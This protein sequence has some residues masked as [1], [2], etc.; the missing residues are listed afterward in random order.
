MNCRRTTN[1]APQRRSPLFTEPLESRTLLCGFVHD[2]STVPGPHFIYGES[3]TT[4]SKQSTTAA[5]LSSFTTLASMQTLAATAALPAGWS[6]QDIGSV[7]KVGSASLDEATGNFAVSGGGADVWSTADGFHFAYSTLTGNGQIVARVASVQNTNGLAKAGVMFRESMTPGSKNAFVQV[8]PTNGASFQ[9]RDAT[10]GTTANIGS[11]ASGK[12]PIWLRLTR[13]GDTFI[14]ARSSNG[15]TWV[16]IASRTIPMAQTLYVGLAVTAHDNA[17]INTSQFTNVAVSGS[18]LQTPTQLVASQTGA[19]SIGLNWADNSITESLFRVQR[20]DNGGSSWADAGTT[21]TNVV[22]YT[23]NAGIVSGTTY[24]YR[25]RAEAGST[26]SGWSTVAT[27]TIPAVPTLTGGDI[28]STGKLG[29]N[30]VLVGGVF[31]VNG[32]GTDIWGAADAFRFVRQ[33][34]TGDGSIIARVTSIQ[35]GVNE[36]T[37]A[38]VMIR[39]SLASNSRNVFITLTPAKGTMFSS[40][41]VAGKS[42]VGATAAGPGAPVWLKLTRSGNVFTSHTSSDGVAWTQ[43]GTVTMTMNATAYVGLAVTSH[44]HATLASAT[45][46]GVK[47]EPAVSTTPKDFTPLFNGVNLNGFYSYSEKRGKNNDVDGFFKA[48]NG[49]LHV[50][51]IPTTTS[52][53]EFAYLATNVEYSNYH[54]RFQYQWGTKKFP[55][56]AAAATPR[57]SGVMYH[58]YG[59]DQLWPQSIETQVQEGDTGDFWMLWDSGKEPT[60]DT[61]IVSG[62]SPPRYAPGGTSLTKKGGRIQKATTVDTLTGWNTVEVI[63]QG[64]AVTVMVNGTVVNR[65]TRARRPDPN[66]AYATIPL[67]GGKIAFQAEGAEIFY[68]SIEIK[69]LTSTP[70]P[71]GATVLFDGTSTSA[72]VKRVGGGAI[73]WP[74]A[75]GAMTVGAGTG[76]IR[77]SQLFG[78]YTLHVEFKTN[79]KSESVTEQDR[80]NSGIALA[81]GYELQVLDSYGRTLSGE[82][83]LGAIYGLR[84]ADVN[85]AMPAGVWQSYDIKFTAARWLGTTKTANARMTVWLNG[86][87]IHSEVAIATNTFTFDPESPGLKPIMFQDHG[88]AVQY[89]NIWVVPAT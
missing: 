78:D 8:K 17:K 44:Q 42:T 21:G 61:T 53:V 85:A 77:T 25:V 83:D 2:E 28:G 57:D 64:D 34:M 62:S 27:V 9:T 52:E 56:R 38:G 66:N 76:D 75:D 26:V 63:A 10:G 86:V 47:I 89:R 33:E 49:M 4:V 80:G 18:P 50:L 60:V 36:W 11:Y 24:S 16:T 35:T 55:P 5:P 29:N 31:T 72:F 14:A 82:N 1:R 70:A 32:A 69:Q 54:L 7:A 30:S 87:L 74:V 43:A 45:F 39:E 58:L 41:S 79:A 15:T 88:N 48:E 19:S 71:T 84:N 73:A 22:A 51:D 37:K 67:T 68:R 13:S 65:I 81:G 46:D 12:A 3:A 40:R 20:S 23:D 59:A 6:S